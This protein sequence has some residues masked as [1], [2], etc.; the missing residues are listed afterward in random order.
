MSASF[1]LNGFSTQTP[2]GSFVA[3]VNTSSFVDGGVF[4]G[5]VLCDGTARLN[6]GS[7]FTNLANMGI[8]NISGSNYVSPNLNSVIMSGNESLTLNSFQGSN[9]ITLTTAQ[10]P[11][12]THSITI[13]D[14]SHTHIYNDYTAD[15][16]S[17]YYTYDD[18]TNPMGST[19]H[20]LTAS[21]TTSSANDAHTHTITVDA[22]DGT[23]GTAFN[24]KNTAF[25]IQ[26]I[27]KYA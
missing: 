18:M 8:G 17:S 26:W 2:I 27:V 6:T 22:V 23:T 1:N 20:S 19:K 7:I 16:A 15:A 12:H 11:S 10:L 13:G 21:E 14:A 25:H 5:W 4:S 9:S 24:T 3:I